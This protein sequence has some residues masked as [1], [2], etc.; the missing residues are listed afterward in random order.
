M[1]IIEALSADCITG[2]GPL[3]TGYI[4]IDHA[5][6]CTIT[7]PDQLNYW[8]F[9]A[10]GGENNLWGEIV[11]TS[12]FGLP[13]YAMS[14]VDLEA[15]VEFSTA[16]L[17][18]AVPVRTFYARYW[19]DGLNGGLSAIV[20]PSTCPNCG[21]GD[22]TTDLSLSSPWNVLYGDAREPLGLKWAGRWFNEGITITSNF[23]VWR[24]HLT[25]LG[26][27][28]E[29][30]PLPPLAAVF[31]D[32]DENTIAGPG[33]PGCTS[34]IDPN[35]CGIVSNLFPWET[36]QVNVNAGFNIP[37]GV[38]GW[39]GFSVYTTDTATNPFEQAWVGYTFEGSIAL[40]SILVPGTQLDPSSC[41][42]LVDPNLTPLA[43]I[44]P[45]VSSIPAGTG[46]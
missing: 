20:P 37:S 45:E 39:V 46:P 1:G 17:G 41:N 31:Y 29:C 3:A 35:V 13:T 42:P 32:E 21:S 8:Q 36:Q 22:P 9:D 11:F 12:G 14:T 44:V 26:D 15:D 2:P 6:Y 16:A 4:V 19:N 33:D 38:A 40:E 10:A 34:P 27:A 18:T 30:S 24:A 5:N 25:N 7:N 43:P 28:S 23:Q